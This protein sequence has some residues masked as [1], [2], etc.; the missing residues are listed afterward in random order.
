MLNDLT[1]SQEICHEQPTI[2]EQEE[3]LDENQELL[4]WQCFKAGS[5]LI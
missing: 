2:I 4:E 1:P 5:H 3:R